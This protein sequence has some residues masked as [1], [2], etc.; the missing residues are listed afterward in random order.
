MTYE[1]I[2]YDLQGGVAKI[3]MNK[4]DHL[5]PLGV[6]VVAELG[7]AFDAAEKDDLI[8]AVILTGSG[9]GFSSGANLT[10]ID[11]GET[12]L[13]EVDVAKSLEDSYNPLIRKMRRM[14]KPVIAAVNGVAVGAGLGLALACDMV[15]AGRS[16]LFSLI[17]TK[18]GLMPDA[19]GTFF[20][21]RKVGIARAMG[22]A[23]TAEQI[24]AKKAEDWGLIWKCV[25]DEALMAEAQILA[26]QFASG[27][28]RAYGMIKKSMYAG[29]ANSLDEQLD[30]EAVYQGWLGKTHDFKEGVAAFVEK[31]PAKFEGR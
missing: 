15:I 31:R 21:A 20:V 25:E 27:P 5:N 26:E 22:M 2:L 29:L 12:D 24:P 3:T 14:E 1:T 4:P 28:T 7:S 30:L 16:A 6:D 23:L 10:A 9:R 18:I 8:R 13:N 11:G 19:G 17:F